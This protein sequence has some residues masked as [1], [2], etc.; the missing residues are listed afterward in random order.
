MTQQ[1]KVYPAEKKLHPQHKG[2]PSPSSRKC[3]AFK[4]LKIRA[5]TY[6]RLLEL[7]DDLHLA[8][9]KKRRRASF[10]NAINFLLDH[11]EKTRG[12]G[13]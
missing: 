6:F 8:F 1:Q 10:N 2:I 12:D 13:K 4:P 3:N 7:K 11:Y 5:D 9:G